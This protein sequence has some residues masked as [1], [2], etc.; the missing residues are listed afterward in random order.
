MRDRCKL[1]GDAGQHPKERA[2]WSFVRNARICV[3]CVESGT[4]RSARNDVPVAIIIDRAAASPAQIPQR[5]QDPA[6]F[7]GSHHAVTIPDFNAKVNPI[8]NAGI[9]CEIYIRSEARVRAVSVI[10]RMAR[11]ET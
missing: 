6:L 2:A 1:V 7:L 8:T 3:G 9:A 4:H 10:S 11:L 5:P